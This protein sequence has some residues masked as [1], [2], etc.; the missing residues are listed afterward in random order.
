MISSKQIHVKLKE[1]LIDII[2]ISSKYNLR[3]FLAGGTCL[4]AVR[5]KG[6][7]PWDDDVDLGIYR[8][9]VDKLVDLLLND[10]RD[11]YSILLPNSK[12][13]G[14]N[15]HIK[16]LSRNV[17]IY[18]P[19]NK[20]SNGNLFIDIFIVENFPNT[21]GLKIKVLA[22]KA[23]IYQFI[24][25]SI[26]FR[27]NKN[28]ITKEIEIRK[29][30]FIYVMKIVTGFFFLFFNESYWFKKHSKISSSFD[31]SGLVFIPSGRKHFLG[32]IFKYSDLFPT[33]LMK[34]ED[35]SLPVPNNVDLYLKNLYNDYMTI[36]KITETHNI[37]IIED[38]ENQK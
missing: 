34:F 22:L 32:E 18:N 30:R 37:E 26:T 16:I 36:P 38:M 9:D 31:F 10:Y 12:L 11:V 24:G 4:G 29:S 1:M 14:T 2:E 28:T 19:Y 5:H 8:D 13:E 6:F 20:K 25:H 17:K 33:K 15:T 35:V 3:I 27:K 21:L 23:N 7:I